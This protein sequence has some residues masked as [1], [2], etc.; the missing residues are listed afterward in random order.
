MHDRRREGSN[1]AHVDHAHET[2]IP[3][4]IVAVEQRLLAAWRAGD[5][6]VCEAEWP[7][8]WAWLFP[9]AIRFCRSMSRDDVTAR[10]W[11]TEAI[12]DAWV[13]VTRRLNEGDGPRQEAGEFVKW[14]MARVILRCRTQARDAF[15]WQKRLADEERTADATA[16]AA[17]APEQES[18][19][20]RDAGNREGLRRFASTL[21]RLRQRARHFPVLEVVVGQMQAYLADRLAATLPPEQRPCTRDLEELIDVADLDAFEV[22]KAHMLQW[23]RERLGIS[24]NVLSVRLHRLRQLHEE[25]A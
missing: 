15:T 25:P 24:S 9:T 11:A 23:I 10:D 4:V 6:P 22:P 13:D 20:I 14:I 18:D 1:A 16:S 5:R 12:A 3:P 2:V 19:L 17:V 7:K 21:T 8:L